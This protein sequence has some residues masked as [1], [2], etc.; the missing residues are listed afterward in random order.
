MKNET[1]FSDE[2]IKKM[3]EKTCLNNSLSEK[4][5][6]HIAAIVD[7]Y[8]YNSREEQLIALEYVSMIL[9]Q[10]CL[11]GNKESYSAIDYSVKKVIMTMYPERKY[12]LQETNNKL[13][14][15]NINMIL[16]DLKV[17]LH[18]RKCLRLKK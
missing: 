18:E 5:V 7:N 3:L 17:E 12:N 16:K 2:E 4:Q 1:K 14:K 15:N 6:L 11:Y 8:K 9:N 13:I 10:M